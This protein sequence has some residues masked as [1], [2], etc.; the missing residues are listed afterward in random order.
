MD[1]NK[2]F[3]KIVLIAVKLVGLC[4][5]PDKRQ[6]SGQ[7]RDSNCYLTRHGRKR[8]LAKVLL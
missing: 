8:Q 3:S 5:V 7:N 6:V 4:G 1:E 2:T